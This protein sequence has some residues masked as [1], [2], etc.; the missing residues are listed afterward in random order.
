MEIRRAETADLEQI[1]GIYQYARE[2]MRQ[3]GNPGQWGENFPPRELIE[4]DIRVRQ[5]YVCAEGEETQGVFAFILGEDP[6][7][8]VIEDGAWL[9]EE[10]YG[11]IHRIA[12]AEGAKG[13]FAGCI[14]YCKGIIDNL[15]IDTHRDNKVMQHVIEKAGFQKCGIIHVADGSERLAYQFSLENRTNV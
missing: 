11:T 10:P 9:N 1:M 12:S 6:T 8:A 7:Y 15:R 13:V 2:F 4:E 5:C 14:T 3:T